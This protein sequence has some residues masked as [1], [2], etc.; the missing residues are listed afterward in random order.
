MKG[1][2]IVKNE[3]KLTEPV[4]PA[5]VVG[6]YAGDICP[7]ADLPVFGTDTTVDPTKTGKAAILSFW[8]TS[9]S[10][11]AEYLAMFDQLTAQHGDSLSVFAVHQFP[12]DTFTP[13]PLLNGYANERVAFLWDK[14]G[15]Y[16][17]TLPSQPMILV[18]DETGLIV[19]VLQYGTD[20]DTLTKAVEAA[21]K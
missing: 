2:L 5:P 17:K 3:S 12:D 1:W 14:D 13:D 4:E 21:M 7:G 15:A 8:G 18:L 10:A 19:E 11:E 20:L 16:Y 9:S 6:S